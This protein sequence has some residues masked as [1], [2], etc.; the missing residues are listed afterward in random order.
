M[1]ILTTVQG[2]ILIESPST[3]G[4]GREPLTLEARVQIPLETFGPVDYWL[5]RRPFKPEERVQSPP[6]LL[7]M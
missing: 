4:L 1:S 3:S 2:E 7:G 6:G 5:D